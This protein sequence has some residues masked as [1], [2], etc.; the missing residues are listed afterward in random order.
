MKKVPFQNL[1]WCVFLALWGTVA[2]YA[3]IFCDA[4]WHISTAAVS[5]LL[6]YFVY[7]DDMN[8]ESVCH[9]LARVRRAKRINTLR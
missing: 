8:G 4:S 3:V 9:Y 7:K 1:C 5:Y 6:A 2:L